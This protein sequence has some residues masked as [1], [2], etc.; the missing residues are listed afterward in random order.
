MRKCWNNSIKRK[1]CNERFVELEQRKQRYAE[2]TQQIPFLEKKS[3]QL[4]DAERASSIE[5]I[6]VQYAE[7]KKEVAEKTNH[8]KKAS[9]QVQVQSEKLVKIGNQYLVEEAKKPER[10]KITESLIPFK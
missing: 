6:E 5:Q 8:L 1:E 7:L 9:E 3:K 4:G 2:L 10:E